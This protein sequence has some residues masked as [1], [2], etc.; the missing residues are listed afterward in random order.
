MAH[1]LSL[2]LPEK[3]YERLRRRAK[4]QKKVV[5]QVALEAVK[6]ELEGPAPNGR[7]DPLAHAD[8]WA[9]PPVEGAPRDLAQ[10]HDYYAYGGS[11]RHASK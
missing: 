6:R 4:R 7:K 9:P 11:K 10:E 8:T 3:L 1:T 5:E 2:K